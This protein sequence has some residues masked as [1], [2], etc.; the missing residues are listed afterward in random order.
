MADIPLPFPG[1]ASHS[2]RPLSDYLSSSLIKLCE[3]W[4]TD[5]ELKWET[6]RQQGDQ[7]S[8]SV[9]TQKDS[10]LKITPTKAKYFPVT[11]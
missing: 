10:M 6:Y 3:Y 7:K 8:L 5:L 11:S 2:I 4:S 1:P 9:F